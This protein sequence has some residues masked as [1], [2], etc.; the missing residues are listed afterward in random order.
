LTAL[1]DDSIC[2]GSTALFSALPA[3]L[4]NYIFYDGFASVQ[5]GASTA[6]TYGS[7]QTFTVT[8]VATED[9][10]NS[11]P[12]NAIK[13]TIINNLPA[14]I[15]NCG[16]SNLDSLSFVWSMVNGAQGYE[17]SINGG[18][19]SAP[20]S[21]SL[22]L[23]HL[24]SGLN[25]NDSATAT[26]RAIGT[27]PCGNSMISNSVTCFTRIC[28]PISF[29]LS[30]PTT[31]CG[32]QAVT[33]I[34]SNILPSTY[35]I[36]WNSG[37]AQ[38]VTT[39]SMNVTTDTTFTAS[40]T[41]TAQPTCPSFTQILTVDLNQLPTPVLTNNAGNDSVCSGQQVV[42]TANPAT[43][44]NYAFYNGL[45]LV[46][47]GPNPVFTANN[48]LSTSVLQV[49]ATEQGCTGV[50][51]NTVS[52]AVIPP[53]QS[54]QVTCG[55]TTNTSIEFDW[56]SVTGATGYE[57]SINGGAFTT[58]SSGGNGLT[59]LITGATQGSSATIEVK[60]LGGQPCGNSVI[61]FAQT[62]YAQNC[63]A[64]SFNAPTQ[65]NLCE[66]DTVNTSISGINISNYSTSWNNG[67]AGTSL[68][69]SIAPTNNI[70]IPVSVT[71]LSEAL[72]PSATKYISVQLTPLPVV[73][74]TSSASND[75]TCSGT[76]ISFTANPQVYSSYS[77][78]ENFALMQSGT[79][80]VYTTS[81]LLNGKTV[82]V[83]VSN[84]G[85]ADTSTNTIATTVIVPL[86]APQVNCG[87]TTNS[88][89]VFTWDAVPDAQGYMVSVNNSSYTTPSS[90]TNGLLHTITGLNT[91]DS[92]TIVVMA[93]GKAPCGN[94]APSNAQTCYAIPC[95]GITFTLSGTTQV[96]QATQAIASISNITPATFNS[97]WNGGVFGSTTSYSVVPTTDTTIH[98]VLKN[99]AEPLCPTAD[100]SIS[101]DF[102][103]KP[104]VTLSL[105]ASNDSV[106][107]GV[108]ITLTASPATYDNYQFYNATSSLASSANPVYITNNISGTY[109]FYVV[110]NFMGCLDTSAANS[111]SIVP[112]PFVTFSASVAND[113]IC[114]GAPYTLTVSP[115]GLSNYQFTYN[116]ST[117]QNS[118]S[119]AYTTSGLAVGNNQ[120]LVTASDYLGC[121][122]TPAD[123]ATVVVL[124]YTSVTLA[125]NATGSICNHQTVLFTASPSG[126][127][128]YTF[129]LNNS[130]VQNG[131]SNVYTNNT[132]TTTDTVRVTST[133]SIGCASSKS[134]GYH[135]VINPT[136]DPAI[137]NNNDTLYY[138]VSSATALQ[139]SASVD[140]ALY[141]PV[142][143]Y[144]STNQQTKNISVNP[145]QS[146]W[147][148][149]Y[150]VFNG[151]PSL[152]D[153]V[154][155]LLDN[156][157]P[158]TVSAS[159][160]VQGAICLGDSI[161]LTGTSNGLYSVWLNGT[162]DTVSKTSSVVVKPITDSVFV[163]RS[164]NKGCATTISVPVK[165]DKCLT[166]LSGPIPQIITPNGD[167]AN[168]NWIVPD[169]DYFQENKLMIYNRWGQLV[170]SQSPYLNTWTGT[171][172]SN[173]ELSEGSY[174]Y[175]LDLGGNYDKK[176]VGFVVIHR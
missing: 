79:N 167:G 133:N 21:G 90:G 145:T 39:F 163:F 53:L 128:Q 3:G 96:C 112:L 56:N 15:L 125:A 60:A 119:N 71:N 169:I 130:V 26:I 27:P 137:D 143:Y 7:A 43:Y 152:L 102:I 8:V 93:L 63:T 127:N 38:G 135:F 134:N 88:T 160:S 136:A 80:P 31:I 33:A 103:N 20:S 48:L 149:V 175:V 22:G 100:K 110:S 140:T 28:D 155:V 126:L 82:K 141:N 37:A 162:N 116:G 84:Q 50:A 13:T 106:C 146:T 157:A 95:T 25:P 65:I 99:T 104:V 156:Q 176:F 2:V 107:F 111:I 54:P 83:L 113:S 10:C 68:T 151:C 1:S 29:T 52:F 72:C 45:G 164:S 158:P 66:G 74:I 77:F 123:T 47:N 73:S 35:A 108:P 131:P 78:Y 89:I 81:N 46:Q 101:V 166:D 9:G 86:P 148:S 142:T 153:S 64:I 36:N 120:I 4:D 122:N 161:L 5:S 16:G 19:Y 92:A 49:I 97:S 55:N 109:S 42:F 174:Y 32:N 24:L 23:T 91:G 76:P 58:A 173:N 132:L 150:T 75:S 44:D 62:C 171:D 98:V 165:V 94:S 129:Y 57:I 17:I 154:L 41:N 115:A 159:S 51:S 121:S 6:L 170:Y 105:S 147:Y 34:A 67:A 70:T 118:S 168:D 144:W 18:A 138:C 117:V 11:L 14:P 40:V 172:N 61:S 59:H 85:C 124:P 114:Q 69:Y 87:T 139:L 12:S 30:G